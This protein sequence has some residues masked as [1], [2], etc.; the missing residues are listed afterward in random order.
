MRTQII[1]I[2]PGK[3]R[4]SR[5]TLPVARSDLPRPYVISDEMPPVEQVDGRYYTSKAAFRRVGRTLGLTEVGN[6]KFK[7]KKRS[8]DDPQV[9]RQRREAI[10]K[11]AAEYRMGRR[12]V[13]A[14]AGGG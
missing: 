2:E 9:K 11:A 3:W 13:P 8:T 7:P 4:V 12:A 6:E 5:E 1:E 10:G 14:K